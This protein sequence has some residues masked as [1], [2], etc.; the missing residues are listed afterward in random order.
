MVLATCVSSLERSVFIVIILSDW[1][2]CFYVDGV[3]S[4]LYILNTNN[5]HQID[6]QVVGPDFLLSFGLP[7]HLIKFTLLNK[8]HKVQRVNCWVPLRRACLRPHFV[9]HPQSY[10]SLQQFFY[11]AMFSV[12]ALDSRFILPSVDIQIS[13]HYLLKILSFLQCVCVASPSEIRWKFQ[14]LVTGSSIL[15]LQFNSI[16]WHHWSVCLHGSGHHVV[17]YH[18]SV[19]LEIG[20][21]D[22]PSSVLFPWGCFEYSLMCQYEFKNPCFYFYTE[23]HWDMAIHLFHNLWQKDED[24]WS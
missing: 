10:L 9:T 14:G 6:V 19:E 17:C 15:D 1:V 16:L 21:G 24:V 3:L 7:L 11:A 23:W 20:Y 5:L 2:I 18:C 8:C 12:G 13:Q 22:I 4:Y